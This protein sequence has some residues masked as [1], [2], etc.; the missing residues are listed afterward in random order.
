MF[1]SRFSAF[2]IFY[3]LILSL[4]WFFIFK[5]KAD[6]HGFQRWSQLDNLSIRLIA[7]NNDA[8]IKNCERF[9]LEYDYESHRKRLFDIYRADS[10]VKHFNKQVVRELNTEDEFLLAKDTLRLNLRRLL[11]PDNTPNYLKI[12]TLF[13]DMYF[14]PVLTH[15]GGRNTVCIQSELILSFVIQKLASYYDGC[16]FSGSNFEPFLISPQTQFL[17]DGKTHLK[18]VA[19]TWKDFHAKVANDPRINNPG[20]ISIDTI[21]YQPGNYPLALKIIPNLPPSKVIQQNLD[22]VWIQVK[23]E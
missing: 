1:S 2:H 10:L 12:D 21:F 22:T 17:K 13:C 5:Y 15:Q 8:V 7:A 20:R 19:S 6:I 4:L 14:D 16:W 11:Y 9:V 18:I 23:P 3:L